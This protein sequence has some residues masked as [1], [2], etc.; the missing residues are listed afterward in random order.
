MNENERKILHFLT[1]PS[2]FRF[3]SLEAISKGTGLSADAALATL[4]NSAYFRREASRGI[5]WT[6]A[7]N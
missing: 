1:G 4:E 6:V 3:R 5:L 2:R 7:T